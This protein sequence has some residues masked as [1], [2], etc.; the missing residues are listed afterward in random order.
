L[1]R[2]FRDNVKRFRGLIQEAG[3]EIRPGDHPIIPIM[4]GEAKLA[5][6]M[7]DMLLKVFM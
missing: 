7:A 6:E 4:L 1:L 5:R 2:R 3:F